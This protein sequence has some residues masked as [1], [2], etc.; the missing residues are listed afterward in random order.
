MPPKVHIPPSI[1]TDL[2]HYPWI[3]LRFRCDY[4]KRWADGGLAACAE[5]FGAATTLGE[6]L[7]LFMSK[8]AWRAEIR[9]P[10]KYGFK[11][12]AYC[13]D[14]GRTRPPD[15]PP[16]IAG[17]TVIDG[18]KDDLLPAEPREIKRRRRVGEE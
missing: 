11:C 6:L 18:G 17:L 13:P 15:L 4:C 8:C 7:K 12:G 5:K 14:I 3:V 9:K 2:R 10:Q 1:E 16:A